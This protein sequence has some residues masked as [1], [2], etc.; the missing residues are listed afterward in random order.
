MKIPKFSCGAWWP[1]ASSVVASGAGTKPSQAQ[2]PSC[3][4]CEGHASTSS[5]CSPL[6]HRASPCPADLSDSLTIKFG[7]GGPIMPSLAWEALLNHH[8]EWTDCSE[9]GEAHFEEA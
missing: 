5:L 7:E 6:P 8:Q 3:L 1:H 2:E 9:Q 4:L